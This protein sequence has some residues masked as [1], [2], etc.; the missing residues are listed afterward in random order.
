MWRWANVENVDLFLQDVYSYYLSSGFWSTLLQRTLGLLTLAFVV[1]FTIFLTNWRDSEPVLQRLFEII[2]AASCRKIGLYWPIR[3]EI[4]L[5][6]LAHRHV[7]AGGQVGLPVVVC[8]A[9]P[10]EFWLWEPGVPLVRGQWDIPVPKERRPVTPE[11]LV[12]PLV[13]FDRA[14]YR[15][16]YGGGFYDRTLAAAAPRPRTIGIG[17]AEAQLRTIHP[18]P[19]DIPMDQIV[20]NEFDLPPD[21]RSAKPT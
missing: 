11:L 8:S 12:I 5:R 9:A 14:Q 2:D 4:D 3:G 7:A 20:T 19:H 21:S 1:G 10:V 16:G 18:Q 13:G 15:L 6:A 17:F